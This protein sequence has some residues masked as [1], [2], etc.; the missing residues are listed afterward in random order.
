MPIRLFFIITGLRVLGRRASSYNQGRFLHLYRSKNGAAKLDLMTATAE[1][2]QRLMSKGILGYCQ[3]EKYEGPC[4]APPS[5]SRIILR[6]GQIRG[7]IRLP[8]ALD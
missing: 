2:M 4:M 6:L 5:Y 3:L 8:E 7:W 1:D